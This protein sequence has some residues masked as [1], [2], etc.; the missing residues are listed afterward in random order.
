M[1]AVRTGIRIGCKE[2]KPPDSVE[3]QIQA[4]NTGEDCQP[5]ELVSVPL[6]NHGL[7]IP[8]RNA[9]DL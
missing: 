6:E 5:Q 4:N 1:Q 8:G 2:C 9:E 7:Y 3:L